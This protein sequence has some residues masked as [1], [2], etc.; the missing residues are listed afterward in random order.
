MHNFQIVFFSSVIMSIWPNNAHS[1][2]LSTSLITCLCYH[3]VPSERGETIA[4]GWLA[5]VFFFHLKWLHNPD[6]LAPPQP[7]WLQGE[8]DT[9]AL[10]YQGFPARSTSPRPGRTDRPMQYQNL[11]DSIISVWSKKKSKSVP[12]N[13]SEEESER[14]SI[15]E[16]G[17][18]YIKC[19]PQT[20]ILAMNVCHFREK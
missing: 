3:R 19:N 16:R 2:W 18:L 10:Y 13:R 8:W 9:H 17:G 4:Q 20:L 11:K 15:T 1:I 5:A 14:E 12:G 7:L 6:S